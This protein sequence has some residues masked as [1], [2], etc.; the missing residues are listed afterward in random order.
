M[1]FSTPE[2]RAVVIDLRAGEELGEHEV[3]ER[4][5]VQVVAGR[6]AITD[7]SGTARRSRPA[8]S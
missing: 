7:G 6:V 8:R 2:C 1:L 3:R 5:V 4:A